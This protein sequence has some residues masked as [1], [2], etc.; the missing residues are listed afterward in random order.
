MPAR[1]LLF[2]MLLFAQI[3]T[4]AQT[5]KRAENFKNVYHWDVSLD[6][7]N[8]LKSGNPAVLLRWKPQKLR[9]AFRLG[10][11]LDTGK[12]KTEVDTNNSGTLQHLYTQNGQNSYSLRFG[13]EF[14][15]PSKRFVLF[16]G[17]ELYYLREKLDID[18]APN[19]QGA[20]ISTPI[21]TNQYNL[22]GLVGV[23]YFILDRLSVS[24]ETMLNAG[25]QRRKSYNTATS[26]WGAIT[27]DLYL[28]FYSL[29]ALNVSFHF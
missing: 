24:S 18:Y 22:R 15:K 20:R 16:Y 4:F 14:Q 11:G 25:L 29:Y 7:Y 1:K 9:G 8:L 10:L 23:R 5:D 27:T 3:N 6:M 19:Y 26:D 28:K 21:V 12:T 13:Y 17:P 2:L